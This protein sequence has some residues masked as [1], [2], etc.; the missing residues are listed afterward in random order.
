MTATLGRLP[1]LWPA[2]FVISSVRDPAITMRVALPRAVYR[3][4]VFLPVSPGC[5]PVCFPALVR[6][7]RASPARWWGNDPDRL[8]SP[9]GWDLHPPWGRDRRSRRTARLAERR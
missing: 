7:R 9:A 3:A 1:F 4:M 5:H 8:D 2:G 6:V